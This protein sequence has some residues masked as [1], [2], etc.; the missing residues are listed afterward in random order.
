MTNSDTNP[1]LPVSVPRWALL[2]AAVVMVAIG[3]TVALIAATSQRLNTQGT[4]LLVT[5]VGLIG[6]SVPAILAA[7][8]AE[9]ASRD[10]RNGVVV[11]KVKQGAT[12]AIRETNVVTVGDQYTNLA[13]DSLAT[14]LRDLGE[15]QSR[16]RPGGRR[17]T[18]PP[19]PPLESPPS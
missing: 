5:I 10:I 19:L 1:I 17:S 9:R 7:A 18:D 14:L 6:T 8:F 12:E 3:A 4:P 13:M 16:D 2:A 11:A 15:R